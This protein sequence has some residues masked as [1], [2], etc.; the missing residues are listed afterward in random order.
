M[1]QGSV[2][3][4]NVSDGGVPKKAVASARVRTSGVDGDRQR[5]LRVHGGPE[6]AVCL[7][8]SELIRALQ[9]E[10][11]PIAPGEIGENLTLMGIRWADVTE[12]R[13]LDVG[14]VRLQVT[15]PVDPCR[16][17]AYAFLGGDFMR[18]S[19][20]AHPGWNRMYARVLTEGVVRVGDPVS[21][22]GA[23]SR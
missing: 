17:I 13:I 9:A 23:D 8:S 20:K 14:E 5:D 16:N 10:G 15:E 4:I 18:V 3:A 11:H 2:V 1:R 7:F 6:R 12:G 19:P 21:I 22:R